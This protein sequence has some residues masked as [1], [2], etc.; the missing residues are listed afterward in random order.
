MKAC[1]ITV[2]SAA[3]RAVPAI[4]SAFSCGI[5]CRAEELNIYRITESAPSGL[6]EAFLNDLNT[7]RTMFAGQKDMVWFRTAFSLYTAQPYMPSADELCVCEN[8]RLL[9]SALRGENMP[10]SYRTDA[11]AA[12]WGFICGSVN[13]PDSHPLSVLKHDLS[14]AISDG[15]HP[16]IMLMYDLCSGFSSGVAAEIIRVL[17]S[18]FGDALGFLGALGL[19][20]AAPSTT[21]S[22]M[23]AARSSLEQLASGGLLRDR[24]HASPA[25]LDAFWLLGLPS[26]F[27]AD[28]DAYRI[29]SYAAA[30]ILAE[31]FAGNDP[32]ASGVCTRKLDGTLTLQ[33]LGNEARQTV[34]FVRGAVW[35]LSDLMPALKSF[36][37]RPVSLRSLA[38]STKDGLFRKIFRQDNRTACEPAD[39]QILE[40]ALKAILLELLTLLRTLPVSLRSAGENADMWQQAVRVCGQAVTVASEYDVCRREADDAGIG[41]VMPV[42]RASMADTEEEEALRKL[43]DMSDQLSAVL[44]ER[45]KVFTSIGGF[46][47]RQALEDCLSRCVSAEET[48]KRRLS[49]MPSDTQEDRFRIALQERRV[50]MLNAAVGR[51]RSDL[52]GMASLPALSGKPV[53]RAVSSS[54][55]SGEILNESAAGQILQLITSDGQD[56]DIA[57]RELQSQAGELF[58]GYRLGDGKTLLKALAASFRRSDASS[59]LASMIAAVFSVCASDT[60]QMRILRDDS[61]PE[62]YLLPDMSGY[63]ESDTLSSVLK[64]LLP[65]GRACDAA[66]ERGMLAALLLMQYRRRTSETAMIEYTAVSKDHSLLAKVILFAR[67]VASATVVSLRKGDLRLPFALLEPGIGLETARLTPLHMDMLPD[68]VTWRDYSKPAGLTD[69]CAGLFESDR[70]ILTEQLTRMRSVLKGAETHPLNVFL[71]SMYQDI[72]RHRSER[73]DPLLPKRLKAVCG[74]QRLPAWKADLERV[75]AF[76]EHFIRNDDLCAYLCGTDSV[77]ASRCDVEDEILYRYRGSPIARE[78]SET[79]L[80]GVGI[81]GEDRLLASLDTECS[82]LFR[83]SDDYHDALASGLTELLSRYPKARPEARA[84]AEKLLSE[85]GE[86]VTDTETVLDW[87]WD[88]DSASVRTILTECIGP[89][90]ADSCLQP[91]SDLLVLFPARGGEV[92]GDLYLDRACRIINASGPSDNSAEEDNGAD[93]VRPADD[94]VLPPLSGYFAVSLCR[95]PEG[96]RLFQ[97]DLLRFERNTDGILA[98]ITLKGAFT[99]KLRRL[100]R[101]DSL[102]SMYT[103]DIPTLAVWPGIPFAADEWH[104]YYAYAHLPHPVNVRVFTSDNEK[105]LSGDIPRV[106][107]SLTS[108]PLCFTLESDGQSL[109]SLPNLLPSPEIVRCGDMTA[110]VDFGSSSTAVLLSGNTGNISVAGTSSA[111][112]LL[113][114]P[115]TSADLMNTEFVPLTGYGAAI[116]TVLR[117]FRNTPGADPVP[118]TEGCIVY[119]QVKDLSALPADTLFT[120]LKWNEEKG[121]ATGM[122]LHQVMLTAAL[123]AR[124][125]GARSLGW[126]FAVPDGMA[127][128]GRKTWCELAAMLAHRVA[129]ESCLPLPENAPPVLFASELSAS[130]AYF[131]LTGPDDTHGG[132]MVLDIGA[133]TSD[134]ALFLRGYEEPVRACQLPLGIWYMLLP[135]LLHDPGTVISDFGFVP[136]ESFQYELSVLRDSFLAARTDPA[137]FR[138][139]KCCLDAFIAERSDVLS[140]ALRRRMA[141]G[142]PGRTG[143]LLLLLF[144]WLMM[145]SGLMLLDLAGDANRNDFLPNRIR[146]CL[147]GRGAALAGRMSGGTGAALQRILTMFRNPRVS[148]IGILISADKKSETPLGLTYLSQLSP[149]VPRKPVAPSSVPVPAEELIPEFLSRFRREFPAEAYL[150]FPRCFSDDPYHIFTTQGEQMI[151]TAISTSFTPQSASRPYDSLAGCIAALTELARDE[152]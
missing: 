99:L 85:A 91:F 9:L 114:N 28:E 86:P 57:A 97:P 119:A 115:V 142:M 48:A 106:C 27:I 118:L 47:A 111:R 76:Y 62:M 25:G 59:P 78:C 31:V 149:N 39:I 37:A 130:G 35:C 72:T 29:L 19:T 73:S 16:R 69:P 88:R 96:R 127:D 14:A 146:L 103:H 123:K 82:V 18:E 50:R 120:D 56:A 68:F 117:I 108:F 80:E 4:A 81:P 151:R 36:L 126:R 40:R 45:N 70:R 145:L 13:A 116:P 34:A 58:K 131:R 110:C 41:K 129:V 140:D 55:F 133:A 51:C 132:F 21:E 20:N 125:E 135:E 71:Q 79:L 148:D 87:P 92:I 95:S 113:R 66:P 30:R 33:V 2:G 11:E 52:A 94:A 17:R 102:L 54:P 23:S 93:P 24:E 15:D 121:R 38:P 5:T 128:E 26:S 84:A 137:S 12:G 61:V 122:Y 143:A 107:S 6:T 22:D 8:D 100:Y 32:S 138:H 46:R 77:P 152:H 105:L 101:E 90:L 7:C 44:E 104:T 64:A 1:L 42:H 134:I 75:P 43:D 147:A 83:S 98:E 49:V 89:E 139:A 109:G 141:D 60:A 74:L 63:E 150:L 65:V 3:D 67:K 124:C 10:L 136:D 144:S 112:M 53:C